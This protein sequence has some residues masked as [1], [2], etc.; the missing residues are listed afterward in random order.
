MTGREIFAKDHYPTI[1]LNLMNNKSTCLNA[2]ITLSGLP[3]RMQTQIGATNMRWG[4]MTLKSLQPYL[5]PMPNT[6]ICH[7]WLSHYNCLTEMWWPNLDDW[8]RNLGWGTCPT[9]HLIL[10][11]NQHTCI[12]KDEPKNNNKIR[13]HKKKMIFQFPLSFS[14]VQPLLCVSIPTT[15]NN[16]RGQPSPP[17]AARNRGNGSNDSS[18]SHK[19]LAVAACKSFPPVYAHQQLQC[20]I[21]TWLISPPPL[22]PSPITKE[23]SIINHRCHRDN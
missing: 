12:K 3:I 6:A 4:G 16:T 17:P 8:K 1:D 22:P 7:N 23:E 11:R 18:Q 9:I 20:Q 2:S 5:V 19:H 21:K 13:K 15:A 14:F 10:I